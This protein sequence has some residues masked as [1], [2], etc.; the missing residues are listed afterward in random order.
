MITETFKVGVDGAIDDSKSFDDVESAKSYAL[1]LW[2]DFSF[3]GDPETGCE[4]AVYGFAEY[5][6][7]DKTPEDAR[8]TFWRHWYVDGLGRVHPDGR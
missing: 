5:S 3:G 8:T 2:E 6:E 7:D 4:A 1:R